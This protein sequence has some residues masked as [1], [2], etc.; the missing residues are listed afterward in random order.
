LLLFPIQILIWPS[1]F[2]PAHA[3]HARP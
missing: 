3:S 1:S 2:L